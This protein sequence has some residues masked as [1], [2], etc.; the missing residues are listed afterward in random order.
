MKQYFFLDAQN[1]SRGPFD[2]ERLK[3]FGVTAD[4]LVWTEGMAEWQAAGSVP[5]LAPLFQQQQASQQQ[6]PQQQQPQYQQQAAQPSQQT[7]PAQQP[8]IVGQPSSYLLGAVLSMLC[9]NPI[10]GAIALAFA[11]QVGRFNRVNMLLDAQRASAKA[12][13]WAMTAFITGIIL[14]VLYLIALCFVGA[15]ANSEYVDIL[16]T[17]DFKLII[18]N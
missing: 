17:F 2:V 9:C 4:T 5:E 18:D 10:F 12:Y 8:Q 6:Q 14:I 1:Q 13:S 7:Q 16:G 3:S 11:L 15:L